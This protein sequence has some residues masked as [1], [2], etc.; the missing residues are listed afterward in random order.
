MDVKFKKIRSGEIIT[1]NCDACR[2]I[3]SA[4]YCFG[5]LNQN[6]RKVIVRIPKTYWKRVKANEK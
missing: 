4:Y 3:Y 1:I 5:V 2:E 6:N